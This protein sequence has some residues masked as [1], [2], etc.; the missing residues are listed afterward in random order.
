MLNIPTPEL[1]RDEWQSVKAALAVAARCGCA[2]PA[3]EGSLR[4]RVGRLASAITGYAPRP[5]ELPA[6]LRAVR[7]FLCDTSRHR[8]IAEHHVPALAGQGYS[9]GQI[10]A[11]ALLGA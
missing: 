2:E 4:A 1:S 5:V 7:D 6:E 11:L 10:E 9:R 3:P 8:R